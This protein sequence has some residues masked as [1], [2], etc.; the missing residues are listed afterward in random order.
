[1]DKSIKKRIFSPT[2]FA[3][4]RIIE[5]RYASIFVTGRF[6]QQ[7]SKESKLWHYS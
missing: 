1:M 7:C 2:R 3:E 4:K 5:R 6:S